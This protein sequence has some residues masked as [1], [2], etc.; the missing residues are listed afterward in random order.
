MYSSQIFGGGGGSFL[1][2][3]AFVS[4]PAGGFITPMLGRYRIRVLGA[5]GG[6]GSSATNQVQAT[7][8]GGGGYCE[9]I[10][11]LPAGVT[12]TVQVGAGGVN[13]A[14][15]GTGGTTYVSGAGLTTM[16][17]NPGTGGTTGAVNTSVSGGVGG[18]GVGGNVF[19]ANGGNGGNSNCTLG[20]AYL[21]VATGGGAA[22]SWMGNGG[23]GGNATGTNSGTTYSGTG[24]GGVG[25]GNGT[26][27]V[28]S[29]PSTTQGGSCNGGAGMYGYGGDLFNYQVPPIN[30]IS[31]P[32][33]QTYFTPTGPM[34]PDVL[35]NLYGGCA[36]YYGGPG[37]GGNSYNMANGTP[38]SHC[39]GG[40][41]GGGGGMLYSN[42]ISNG[43]NGGRGAG[44]GANIQAAI[45]TYGGSGLVIIEW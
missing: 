10:V 17:A 16:T 4:S 34:D 22:G 24:G 33:S 36:Q 29:L 25:G 7:G 40:T 15:G 19:N 11:T 9:S 14:P 38:A 35:K 43:P 5:G 31:F 8:G 6:G 44:A 32:L 21:M 2:L 18:T 23:R 41:C 20:G 26:D 13:G 28:V 37:A 1:R 3:R 39:I 42:G 45:A 30:G 27:M 12:L